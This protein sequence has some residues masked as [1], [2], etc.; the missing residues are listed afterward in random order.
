MR[1]SLAGPAFL[2]ALMALTGCTSGSTAAPDAGSQPI[3]DAGVRFTIGEQGGTLEMEGATL[4]VPPGALD[5][6]VEIVLAP[7]PEAP[8][9]GYRL[10]TAAFRI[11]PEELV[12]AVPATL[13][14]TITKPVQDE[15]LV[16]VFGSYRPAT[17]ER[18][19]ARVVGGMA[20]VE[21][22]RAGTFF[23]GELVD[24]TAPA[25][26]TCAHVRP[27]AIHSPDSHSAAVSI[28]FSAVD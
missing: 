4:V 15:T 23:A 1:L 13:S 18:L 9:D 25:N 19:D 14:L 5:R 10:F 2:T 11:Q 8:P 22:S 7:S 6:P 26:P 24:Y 21:L 27:L 17:F 16:T 3:A 12:F 28:F 20:T